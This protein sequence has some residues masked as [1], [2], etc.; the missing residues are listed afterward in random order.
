MFQINL[1]K[2]FSGHAVIIA[3]LSN[4]WQPGYFPEASSYGY[5]IYQEKIATVAPGCLEVLLETVTRELK[6][7]ISKFN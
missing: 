3:T 7:M 2:R 6:L 4:E 5:G 1:R